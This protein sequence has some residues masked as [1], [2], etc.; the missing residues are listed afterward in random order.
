M[1]KHIAP[2]SFVRETGPDTYLPSPLTRVLAS[3][4]GEGCVSR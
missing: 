4:G 1:L 2:E 3:W